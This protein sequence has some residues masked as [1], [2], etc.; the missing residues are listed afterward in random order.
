MAK[1]KTEYDILRILAIL[2]VIMIHVIGN[3]FFSMTDV[4]S[5]WW[6]G[7]NLLNSGLRW[8]VPVL[9]MISGALFL[10]P[11]REITGKMLF[12]KSIRRILTAFT[13]WSVLY[14]IVNYMEYPR[15]LDVLRTIVDFSSSVW[16]EPH[17]HLWFIYLILGLYVITPVLRLVTR[18]ASDDLLLYWLALMAVF[19]II[20]PTMIEK[21]A[22][23]N[24]MFGPA[25]NNA[26]LDFL[27]GYVFYY[28]AGYYI[29][30]K[31]IRHEKLIYTLGI[32]GYLI[33]V[34]GTVHLSRQASVT[35]A[36]YGY[37]YPNTAMIAVAIFT[38]FS[39][40]VS[41]WHLP[42]RVS[43]FCGK[44]ASCMF[45]VYLI[46]DFPLMILNKLGI[47]IAE[48]P[49]MITALSIC[50]GVFVLCSAVMLLLQKIEFARK[51]LM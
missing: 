25:M 43:A 5:V 13:F 34:F 49:G 17:Y 37:L 10:D 20:M 44:L 31:K 14:T 16:L 1:R 50:A 33:T 28:L 2:A 6:N 38:F 3:T 48:Y 18:Y 11:G 12:C 39:K 22:F 29:S 7:L 40:R 19:G 36:M 23:M 24:S 42:D 9:V 15:S 4:Q 35:T 30:V 47:T 21:S 8:C 51:H 27:G 46:H 32:L 45:G 41:L 26:H